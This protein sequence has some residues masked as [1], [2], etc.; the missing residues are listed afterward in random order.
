MCR[1]WISKFW[2]D[3][4][5][6]TP[7]FCCDRN[8]FEVMSF[9]FFV[10][11]PQ[12]PNFETLQKRL[13]KIL[14][15][16]HRRQIF[17]YEIETCRKWISKLWSPTAGAVS[18]FEKKCIWSGSFKNFICPPQ[19]PKFFG[20]TSKTDFENGDRNVVF[21]VRSFKSFVCPPQTP[22]CRKRIS[23][24]WSPTST[25]TDIFFRD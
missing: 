9:K 17:F 22:M 1:R 11:P 13:F 7:H 21:A 10:C 2:S 3:R 23:K 12:A 18:F 25:G 15:A 24:F 16:H 6:Q 19:T 14:V 8:V 20:D 4:P 5:P